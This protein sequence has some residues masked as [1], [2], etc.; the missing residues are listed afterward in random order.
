[1]PGLSRKNHGARILLSV[2][3]ILSDDARV[4]ARNDSATSPVHLRRGLLALAAVLF[5]AVAAAYAF[6]TSFSYFSY[7]DD[8]GTLM[9]SVRGYLDGQRLYDEMPSYYGPFYYYYEW[10]VHRLAALPLT[11]DVT[12]ALCLFHWLGA[13][14]LLALAGASMARSALLGFFI[15]M[16]AALHLTPL[17]R[18]PGHPQEL[19]AVLL[20]LAVL[21]ARGKVSGKVGPLLLGAIGA[22]L[23]FTKINVGGF[24]GFALVL[25]LCTQTSWLQSRR[26]VF[27]I[28]LLLSSVLPFLLMRPH[29]S[30]A[31]ARVYA[32]QI[33]IGVLTAGAMALVFNGRTRNPEIRNP[34]SEMEQSL[35]RS[36]V[37]GLSMWGWVVAGSA[38]LSVLLVVILLAGHSTLSALVENLVTGP[39]KLGSAFSVPLRV[40]NATWSGIASLIGAGVV[41]TFRS[42]PDRL[43]T[44]VAVAKGLF[45]IAGTI[46]LVSD[47][48]AQLGYLLPW[49][50]LLL[51]PAGEPADD[52]APFARTF[53]CLLAVWQGL[54]AYPTAGTQVV[55]ATVLAVLIYSLCLHDAFKALPAAER[56]R[57]LPP[58][59]QGL[60]K[61][62]GVAA[63]LILFATSWCNPF[64]SRRYYESVPSLGLRGAE[65]L[66][67]PPEQVELYRALTQYVETQSDTFITIPGLNSLH[68]WSG[69][70][71]PTFFIIA[72]VVL[73]SDAQQAQVAA[74]LQKAERPLILI[75]KKTLVGSPGDGPLWRLIR[76]QGHEVQQ[77][78]NYQ[79]LALKRTAA[80]P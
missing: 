27:G 68:F 57:T 44:L 79:I 75:N 54:Q 31:W 40:P 26:A 63:L 42:Q 73:L 28:V 52:H 67:L 21:A 70:M 38:G 2:A 8:E 3:T 18:E 59:S 11:H 69:K 10:L 35:P 9:I 65:F 6:N 51:V 61:A 60:L 55:I 23:V 12:R 80:T 62:G 34:K 46:L 22:I 50:W 17:A 76:E 30:E 45:G 20:P 48:N 66:R 41:I 19:I 49:S 77:I 78:G 25:A 39:A 29:L 24:Y 1:L 16:Q 58:R 4:P 71:P 56:L 37:S 47:C 14:A 43:K 33:S 15:F 5:L 64:S 53:L 32:G 72:E 36:A 7:Y 13:A 74:A